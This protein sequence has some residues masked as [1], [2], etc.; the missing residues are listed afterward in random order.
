MFRRRI[1]AQGFT[2]IA[3]VVGSVYYAGDREKRKELEG[4]MSE[5]KRKEKHEKWVR[6]LEA[7]DEEEKAVKEVLRRRQEEAD[8]LART[9]PESRTVVEEMERRGLLPGWHIVERLRWAR[10]ED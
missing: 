6:E 2:V 3:M 5:Q 9:Y 7:R 8:R 1:Y 10:R 4:I